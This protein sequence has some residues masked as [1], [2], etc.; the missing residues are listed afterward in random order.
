MKIFPGVTHTGRDSNGRKVVLTADG[1]FSLKRMSDQDDGS[2]NVE[3]DWVVLEEMPS[4]EV[5]QAD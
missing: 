5:V 2:N 1:C 4:R 3:C